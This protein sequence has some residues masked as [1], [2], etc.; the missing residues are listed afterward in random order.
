MN[1]FNCYVNTYGIHVIWLFHCFRAG[2]LERF[3]GGGAGPSGGG[4][5]SM[6]K[7]VLERVQRAKSPCGGQELNLGTGAF[8]GICMGQ[9]FIIL[10]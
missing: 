10:S 8:F 7:N 9:N 1:Q 4:R 6:G 2:T 5:R 3:L